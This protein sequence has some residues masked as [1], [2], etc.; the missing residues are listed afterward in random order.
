MSPK[1]EPTHESHPFHDDVSH[2]VSWKQ[3]GFNLFRIAIAWQHAQTELGG[4]L[5]ETSMQSVDAMVDAIT[6]DG[7]KAILDIVRSDFRSLVIVANE[8]TLQHNYGRWYCA[9]IGQPENSFQNPTANVTN[10]HFVDLWTRIAER[11]QAN[12][13]VIFQLMN[14]RMSYHSLLRNSYSN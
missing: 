5:N 1:C 4:Q 10:K 6:Q 11:Y 3:E 14:E 12:S 13:N 7:G 2:Y 8:N 9:I